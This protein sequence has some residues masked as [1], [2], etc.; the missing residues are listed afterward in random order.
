MPVPDWEEESVIED[1]MWL[2]KG[3]QTTLIVKDENIDEA[4]DQFVD[5]MKVN[6]EQPFKM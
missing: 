5:D 3:K 2:E 1:E 6:P 4:I